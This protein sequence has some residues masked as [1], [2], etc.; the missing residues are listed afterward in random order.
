MSRWF[1]FLMVALTA[2]HGHAADPTAFT[3][4]QLTDLPVNDWL[5]N[6]GNVFNQRYSPL[7]EI[8]TGN[9]AALQAEWRT[10][11]NGSGVGPPFS[12]E[13]QPIVEGGVIYVSTG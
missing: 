5:T 4:K 9:V 13:A 11:L 6:G 2:T 1:L 7:A 12:G 3:A 8:N 10:H